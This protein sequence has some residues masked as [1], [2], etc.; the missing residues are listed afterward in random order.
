MTYRNGIETEKQMTTFK[1]ITRVRLPKD[2][3][4]ETKSLLIDKHQYTMLKETFYSDKDP[5]R[6]EIKFDSLPSSCGVQRTEAI[7][8]LVKE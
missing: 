2:Y 7:Y 6:M 4:A 3:S 5:R 1:N 8:C